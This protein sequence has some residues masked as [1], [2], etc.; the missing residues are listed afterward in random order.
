[1]K[2][3]HWRYLLTS[4]IFLLAPILMMAQEVDWKKMDTYY[5]QAVKDWNIPSMTVGVVKDGKL[6]FSKGYGVKEIGKKE[7]PDANT[8]YAIASNSKA[9]TSAIIAMLVQEGK[10]DW[11]DKVQKHLPYFELYNPCVTEATTIRDLLCHRVGLGTFSGDVI[12]YK[13]EMTAEEIIR[14]VKNIPPAYNFRSGYGYSNLMYITAGEVIR[15]ITGKSWGENVTER[16]LKPL[17]MNRTIYQLKALDKVGNYAT[18]HGLSEG[19]NFPIPW[20]N[21]ETVAATG[22]LISSVGDIAKWLTFNMNHGVLNG[23]TLLTPHSRNTLW[24]PHNNFMVDHTEDNDYERNFNAYALGWGVSDYHGQMRVGHTGGYD[25]MITA[26]NMIPDKKLGV[27][28]LTNGM[29][30]PIMPITYYTLDA[31]LGVS[32]KDWSKDFLAFR[33]GRKDTRVSDAKEKRVM[34][35]KPSVGKKAY[36]GTYESTIYGKIMISL[37]EDSLVMKFEHTP[38]YEATLEHWHYD[39]WEIKWKKDHAWFDFGTVKFNSDNNLEITGIDFFVPNDDI[40][41]EELKPV[42]VK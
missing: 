38:D 19:T 6:I 31:L 26:I 21:W 15:T 39:V 20:A 34:D 22:G 10:L 8:L 37:E 9:F 29:N 32:K 36:V 7:K 42:K 11:D 1:M 27:I 24:K 13:A 33:E 14:K 41:F 12:W 18:P 17:G 5:E 3:I 40:F 35:T 28:V 4:T 25:G 23:D 2:Y 30:S 16:I